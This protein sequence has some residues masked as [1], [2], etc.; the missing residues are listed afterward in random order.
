M[1]VTHGDDGSISALL[2]DV[3]AET[4]QG[5]DDEEHRAS[6][7]REELQRITVGTRPGDPRHAARASVILT[8]CSGLPSQQ[9]LDDVGVRASAFRRGCEL[10]RVSPQTPATVRA[11]AE[12]VVHGATA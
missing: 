1:K 8:A 2:T 9:F 3:R 11:Q 10:L 12:R 5:L 6:R 7:V 4:E